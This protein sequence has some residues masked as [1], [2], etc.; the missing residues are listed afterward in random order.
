M[1]NIVTFNADILIKLKY[2]FTVLIIFT[3]ILTI[4]GYK[5]SDWNGISEEEDNTLM[6]KFF[7]RFY[8]STIT[9]STIG[10]G[11]I[12]PRTIQLKIMICAFALF[13]VLA[14]F[15]TVS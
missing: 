1:S 6:Q 7:N 3:L 10:Y 2:Y 12:T 14:L 8:F 4:A 15:S 11:Q 5:T 13:V 9:A